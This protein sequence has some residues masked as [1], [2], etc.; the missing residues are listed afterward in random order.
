LIA[1]DI[2]IFHKFVNRPIYIKKVLILCSI[3][4]ANA[5]LKTWNTQ[6]NE[7]VIPY[8]T[9]VDT[10]NKDDTVM[11][12]QHRI[13]LQKGDG[14]AAA[15]DARTPESDFDINQDNVVATEIV[16]SNFGTGG[17]KEGNPKAQA[18][19]SVV[20][21]TEVGPDKDKSDSGLKNESGIFE[22]G[23]IQNVNMLIEPNMSSPILSKDKETSAVNTEERSKDVPVI[24]AYE[25]SGEI[26][27]DSSK[28]MEADSKNMNSESNI[29]S[30]PG[31]SSIVAE[32]RDVPETNPEFQKMFVKIRGVEESPAASHN[33]TSEINTLGP[34]RFENEDSFAEPYKSNSF[35]NEEPSLVGNKNEDPIA[36]PIHNIEAYSKQFRPHN[37]NEVTDTGVNTEGELDSFWSTFDQNDSEDGDGSP[38]NSFSVSLY[39][40]DSQEDKTQTS[41]DKF[42]NGMEPRYVAH[43]QDS[44]Y[45]VNN[46]AGSAYMRPRRDETSHMCVV[47]CSPMNYIVQP[48][49]Y[50]YYGAAADQGYSIGVQLPPVHLPQIQLPPVQFP[51]IFDSSSA[52]SSVS[53]DGHGG[54]ASANEN[55]QGH[56][57]IVTSNSYAGASKGPQ[58]YGGAS[59]SYVKEPLSH[60]EYSL[61]TPQK[62]VQT[63]LVLKA[64]HPYK[65]MQP[66][67]NMQPYIH[68]AEQENINLHK[69]TYF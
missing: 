22:S 14:E 55:A 28:S 63:S 50:G 68:H 65:N 38:K 15:G 57:Y 52:F 13:K 18:E 59:H 45:Y 48:Y 25:K 61:T 41:L 30:E 17:G 34:Q 3:P 35:D 23:P 53:T 31:K 27:E 24:I 62:Y 8:S 20:S 32:E 58:D 16:Q 43:S 10:K 33:L 26:L 6:S 51:D 54:D 66:H 4:Q 40:R 5:H 12:K 64:P 46:P 9:G 56:N 11:S 37:I 49:H 29:V 39:S 2:A 44:S 19:K 60:M 42:N 67:K 47:P 69:S 21:E 7:N 1:L 36:V